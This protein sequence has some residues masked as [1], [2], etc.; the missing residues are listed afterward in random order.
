MGKYVSVICPSCGGAV[1]SLGDD[2]YQCK[3]CLTEFCYVE[4]SEEAFGQQ[5]GLLLNAN[6]F[7]SIGR[8]DDAANTYRVIIKTF[9]DEVRAYWGAFLSEYGIEY[10]QEDGKRRPICHRISRL[11]AL[12][13]PDLKELFARCNAAER[14]QYTVQAE[15]IERIRLQT[16]EISKAQDKYEIFICHGDG[17]GEK[18]KAEEL[19]DAF[20]SKGRKVFLP[21]K[22]IPRG[23]RNAEGY[24]Y[25]AIESASFLFVIAESQDSIVRTDSIWRRFIADKSKKT[26][27]LHKG[28]DEQNFPSDL[29]RTVQRQEPIDLRDA[30]WLRAAEA[31]AEKKDKKGG[32]ASSAQADKAYIEEMIRKLERPG[33]QVAAANSLAEA[34]VMMLSCL[35]AGNAYEGERVLNEQLDRFRPGAIRFVGELCLELTKLPKVSEAER[36]NC[37][38][39]V[40]NIASRLRSAAPALTLEER[41]LYAT[42][43]NAKL[44]V[45][46]AKCF[47]VI[48]DGGRQCFVLDMID[49]TQLYDT[50]IVNELIGMLFKNGRSEDVK[51]VLR[52]VPQMDGDYVLMSLLKNFD[53]KQ[54][55]T[56]LLDIAERLRCSDAIEDD[57]NYWLSDCDDTDVALSVVSI[58]NDNKISLSVVALGG[59]L[60]RVS[61]AAG[62][63]IVLDNLGKRPLSGPEVDKLISIGAEN[64][65]AV[66]NEVLGYLHNVA[67]I[68]DIGVHNMYMLINKCSLE[69]IK[70]RL[71]AFNMDKQLAER[72]LGETLKTQTPDRLSNVTVLLEYMPMVDIA[73]YERLLLGSDPGKKALLA[74]LAP[75]TGKFA[76]YNAVIEKFLA[77]P[78]DDDEDKREIFAMYG[79]FPFSDRATE[80]YLQ[81][82]PSAY[83]E[84]YETRLYTYLENNPGKA[85]E[86]FAKHYE[87]LAQG[88]ERVLPRILGYIRAMPDENIVRFVCDFRGEQS[89]KDDL[90]LRLAAFSDKPKNIEVR[91]RDVTCN[92]AQ[93]YLLTLRSLG[94][95]TEDVLNML[96]K[97]GV[98]EDEKVVSYGKKLK[99]KD[100]VADAELDGTTRAAIEKII[101]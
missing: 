35:A 29:R 31:F 67:K 65:A 48:K 73:T 39:N 95:R 69:K 3:Y 77:S 43:G 52:S 26:Q 101:K 41:E 22:C 76:G 60:S 6:N 64:G 40:G 23:E 94:A 61:D 11:S 97:K 82:I 38:A 5:T 96:R 32:D 98:K 51:D 49:Y 14:E 55:Q 9:P 54:K 58:M 83:D 99:F 10:V 81:I 56:L 12:D 66:A 80:L 84:A 2:R 24:I 75:K 1:T 18:E 33:G 30:H 62:I 89:V 37:M 34:F 42:V 93:A 53:N 88:Y 21:E 4:E 17:A 85:R 36:R 91:M 13:S 16:Y 15:E 7:L 87:A 47:G 90:F 20:A 45:F 59:A 92:L 46:L 72:L 70:M 100:Y 27:V 25:P 50:R 63:R 28:L 74:L 44:L 79:D 19:Y 78:S 86:Q 68:S 57:L 71:F 8:F